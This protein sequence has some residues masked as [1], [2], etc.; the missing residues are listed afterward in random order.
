MIDTTIP[1][2]ASASS[3]SLLD[4]AVGR[5]RT[6]GRTEVPEVSVVSVVSAM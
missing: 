1:A 3:V 4:L 6:P 5:P 2:I